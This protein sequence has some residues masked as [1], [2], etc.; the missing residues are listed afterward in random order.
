MGAGSEEVVGASER[1]TMAVVRI[2]ALNTPAMA[3]SAQ[4]SACL[5]PTVPDYSG[6][7]AHARPRIRPKRLIL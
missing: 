6:R 7:G 3:I 4:P 1:S 5:R 2:D